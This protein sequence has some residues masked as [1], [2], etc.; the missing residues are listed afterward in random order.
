MIDNAEYAKRRKLLLQQV[1]SASIILLPSALECT[2]SADSLYPFRQQSDFYYLTGF[3][4]PEALLALIPKRTQGEYVLF[5]RVRDF[6][7]EIWDGERAGQ[8]G[9]CKNFQADQAFSIQQLE[10]MLPELLLDRQE[11]YYPIGMNKRFDNILLQAINKIRSMHRNGMQSPIAF[12]DV[13]PFIHEMRLLKSKTEISLMQ[14]AV[15]ITAAA[16]LRAMQ[17]CKP[18]MMEYQLEAEL[19]FEFYRNGS[20]SSAYQPIVGSGKNSCVLHYINNNQK[21]HDGDLVLIDAGAE[22]ENYAAD[23]TRTFPVNGRFSPEQKAIYEIV[24]AAQLAAIKS[25]K[26]GA[27][28]TKAQE[29]IVNIITEGLRD[30]GILK[31]G[32]ND[33]IAKRAY[34]PFYMHRS[35]H[36]L[37]LDVHDVGQYKDG[38][39]WRKLEANM[40]LTVEPGIYINASAKVDK[41]W[42]N[43]G[44]RIEDD[45]LVTNSGC[46]VLSEKLPRQVSEIE[47]LMK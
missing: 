4:E 29:I 33:L 20:R 14:H 2:R 5:N 35:G 6:E 46:R 25:I 18:G 41:R 17:A 45:V 40:V 47:A 13:L 28:W 44:I 19:Q 36:W 43:I 32:L 31:G 26:P 1:N 37:G 8:Q 39:Q 38:D 11:I 27:R 12:I 10:S 16:H 30:L 34:L 15:D 24:L 9:A 3:N 21:M 22:Y 23:I 7:R 42:H